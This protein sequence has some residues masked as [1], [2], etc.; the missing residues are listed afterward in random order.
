[1]VGIPTV[2]VD[3]QF[4]HTQEECQPHSR[5]R[6]ERAIKQSIVK[7]LSMIPIA[8][9]PPAMPFQCRISDLA[10]EST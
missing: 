1:M 7:G 8:A 3:K 9:D 2:L 4:S 6:L 5:A 10:S